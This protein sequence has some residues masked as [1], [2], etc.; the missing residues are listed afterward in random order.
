MTCNDLYLGL[1]YGLILILKVLSTEVFGMYFMRKGH[2]AETC[3]LGRNNS[4]GLL[5]LFCVIMSN[6]FLNFP[7]RFDFLPG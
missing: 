1:I 6:I 2:D 7:K 4:F 5:R 3:T